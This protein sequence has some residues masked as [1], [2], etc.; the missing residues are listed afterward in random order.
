MARGKII[1]KQMSPKN[2]RASVVGS[3]GKFVLGG[4]GWNTLRAAKRGLLSA[5][6]IIDDG[7]VEILS[8][9]DQAAKKREKR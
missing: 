6:K 4:H 8:M 5:V 9:A 1:Y 7:R 2:W 3:N